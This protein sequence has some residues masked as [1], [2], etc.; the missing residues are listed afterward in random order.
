MSHLKVDFSRQL[1]E[2]LKSFYGGRL[3]SFATIARDFSLR[4]PHLT[5]LSAETV[6][7]WIRGQAL[8]HVS[9]MQVLV[10]WLGPQMTASY[11]HSH[12]SNDLLN[13]KP[14][15]KN[16]SL[17]NAVG[18]QQS[19]PHERN[20]PDEEHLLHLMH[21][22]SIEEQQAVIEIAELLAFKGAGDQ[23][24]VTK[25]Q[26]LTKSISS[27]KLHNGKGRTNKV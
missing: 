5:H 22:L 1:A 4:A 17:G 11:D 8:P 12:H 21:S 10:D 3:P 27:A 26:Q 15:E 24:K 6:R 25:T 19:E 16:H 9:R 2:G 14:D 7:Q 23:L 18:F 20:A 13:G